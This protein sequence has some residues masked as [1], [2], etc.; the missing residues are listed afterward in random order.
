MAQW[1]FRV[2]A[3]VGKETTKIVIVNMS[4]RRTLIVQLKSMNLWFRDEL[5]AVKLSAA[6]R[7][8]NEIP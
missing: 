7:I 5:R 4:W 6:Q 1:T 8:F 3:T 2:R